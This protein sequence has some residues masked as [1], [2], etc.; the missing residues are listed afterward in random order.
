MIRGLVVLLAAFGLAAAAPPVA[1][2]PAD[3][4]EVLANAAKLL[5]QR[6]VDASQGALLARQLRRQGPR[7]K[8]IREPRAFADSVTQWLRRAS[9]DGHLG[10]SFSEQPIA[11]QAGESAFSAAEME[12][13]YGAQLN[14][15]IEK[16][17][18]LD[19][20]IMLLDLR[21]FPPPAM[22][23]DVI[24][25]A[26][27]VV[28]QGDALIIDLRENGGGAE[29]ASLVAGYLVERG[30]P[31]SGSYDRPSGI[32]RANVSPDWVPGRRFGSAKPLYILTSRK[33]FSAAEALAYDLQALKRATIVG[34]TTG[35]GAHPYEYRRVHRHFALDL[36][37]GRS[38]NPITGGNWQGIGVKPDVAVP[39]AEALDRALALARTAI[40]KDR[41]AASSGPRSLP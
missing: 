17:E 27:T 39:A 16:I 2:T 38:V 32:H 15:G 28:A 33:T 9:G 4:A 26:M 31:L 18:R 8:T 34:E 1:L 6:Y 3:R 5:E 36:P 41:S 35:G 25:A 29:T 20:N 11:N 10:L 12:R 7:W 22:A 24:A 37:E 13:W 23:G 21:V 30:S 19:G 14:H 40:A